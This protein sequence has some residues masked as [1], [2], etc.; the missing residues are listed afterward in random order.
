M[1]NYQYIE[2]L[3][4][5]YFDCQTSV[6]EE[7]ILRTFF[8]QEE[9]P[10]HLAQYAPLFL[11]DQ[12]TSAEHLGDDFDK[13]MEALIAEDAL[14]ENTTV[15]RMTARRVS[16][17]ER[18]SPL[19]KAAAVVALI[20]GVGAAVEHGLVDLERSDAFSATGQYVRHADV[21]NVVQRSVAAPEPVV[22][23]AQANDS[24]VA[25]QLGV[26]DMPVAT[27]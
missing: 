2:Q 26:T 5:R 25:P 17:M 14:M 21:E 19:F 24:I 13:R 12:A 1:M 20:V 9:V 23:T 6:E 3:L 16:L 15:V 11:L 18:L 4:E 7:R 8:C 27:E 22:I 10:A